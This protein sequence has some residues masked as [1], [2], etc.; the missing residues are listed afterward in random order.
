MAMLTWFADARK[1][2]PTHGDI[3]NDTVPQVYT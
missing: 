3:S 1:Q 2:V